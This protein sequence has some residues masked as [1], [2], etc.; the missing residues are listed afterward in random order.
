VL[1]LR[2]GLTSHA[3]VVMRGMGKSAVVGAQGLNLDSAAHTLTSIQNPDITV[4][5]GDT[6]TIDGS[7]GYVY[8]GQM[9]TVSVGQDDNFRTVMQWAD[10][11]K[12]LGVLTNA[13][14]VEDVQQ[15]QRM[16]A[17]GIGLCRTEHMFFQADRI[18]LFRSMILA[19]DSHERATWLLKLQPLQQRD[20]LEIFRIVGDAQVTIRLLDPPLHEFLPSPKSPGFE[21]EIR[22]LA[23]R[24]EIDPEE[25]Q[26]RVL[27]LQ[28]SNPMLGF[29]GCRLAIVYP[30]ITEMQTKAIISKFRCW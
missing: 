23:Q 27:D 28:E 17:E 10:R 4:R 21:E 16:G 20:F 2:G 8:L 12:R 9:P 14:T 13:E 25:C 3:A 6:I 7:T 26:R 18:N 11:N 5:T 22:G 24:L 19:Q 15:A 29:R 30:E 1:T